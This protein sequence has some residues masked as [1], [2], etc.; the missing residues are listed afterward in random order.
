MARF[1]WATVVKALHSL[2]MVAMVVAIYYVLYSAATGRLDVWLWLA[3]GVVAAEGGVYLAFGRR[4]PLT[5]WAKNLGDETG[6]DLLGE[7]LLPTSWLRWVVPVC[8]AVFVV[9]LVWLAVVH[10]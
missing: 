4:C 1:S 9:G 7:W 3:I 2:V 8:A 6:H 5:L 10:L